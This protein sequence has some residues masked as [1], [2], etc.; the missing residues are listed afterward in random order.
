MKNKQYQD[1]AEALE[2]RNEEVHLQGE[3]FAE[4]QQVYRVKDVTTFLRDGI[5]LSK[6]DIF[7]DLFE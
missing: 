4:Q 1:I 3:T 6:R 5:P 2:N 7:R